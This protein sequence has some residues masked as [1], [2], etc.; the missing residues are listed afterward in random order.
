M[1]YI[2]YAKRLICESRTK[3]SAVS[4]F[5]LQPRSK[6]ELARICKKAGT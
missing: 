1:L 2:Y 5:I 4:Q 6:Q 3:K